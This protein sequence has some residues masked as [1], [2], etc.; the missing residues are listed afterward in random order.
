MKG[1][2]T[3]TVLFYACVLHC[4]RAFSTG[5]RLPH[6]SLLWLTESDFD[7]FSSVGDATSADGQAL[8]NQFYQQ[9]REREQSVKLSEEEARSM[10]REA[11]DRR[12]EVVAGKDVSPMARKFTGRGVDMPS[13]AG[14]FSGRGASVYSVPSSTPRRRMMQNELD[15]ASRAE[16]T[17]LIQIIATLSLLSFAVYVGWTGGIT[18]NDWSSV[19]DSLDSSIE[20]IEAVLPVPTDT[21]TSVWL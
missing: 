10:N 11:F 16:R 1:I 17:L 3:T 5:G 18:S 12:R 4:G 20:G 14:L 6:R 19:A 2:C 9:L 7:D 15:L 8:A 13:S 21:E